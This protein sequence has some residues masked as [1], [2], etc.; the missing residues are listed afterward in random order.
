[1]NLWCVYFFIPRQIL[2]FLYSI[3]ENN[4][5]MY[6]TLFVDKVPCNFVIRELYYMILT[7]KRIIILPKNLNFSLDFDPITLYLETRCV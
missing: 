4:E 1:M 3:N 7:N 6:I 2:T 5:C